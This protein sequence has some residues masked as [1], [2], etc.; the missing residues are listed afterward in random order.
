VVQQ[1]QLHLSRCVRVSGHH[2]STRRTRRRR[3]RVRFGARPQ[4]DPLEDG[5][6]RLATVDGACPRLQVGQAAQREAHQSRRK[7]LLSAAACAAALAGLRAGPAFAGEVK[8]PPGTPGVPNSGSGKATGAPAHAMPGRKQPPEPAESVD[9]A[10]GWPW[11]QRWGQL[12]EIMDAGLSRGARLSAPTTE[13]QT[14]ATGP[15]SPSFSWPEPQPA[16]AGV[17][18]LLYPPRYIKRLTLKFFP[19]RALPAPSPR[20]GDAAPD[21][22]AS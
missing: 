11:R 13:G 10:G 9:A 17:S 19:S 21:D 8:G 1:V 12:E 2:L 4:P 3:R 15:D 14:D 16:A 22:S 7:S 18:R 6:A 5:S 20:R